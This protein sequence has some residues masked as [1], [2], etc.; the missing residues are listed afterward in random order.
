MSLPL[1]I[2]GSL[3]AIVIGGGNYSTAL[4]T[5]LIILICLFYAVYKKNRKDIVA[6]AIITLCMTIS[7]VISVKAPGNAVRQENFNSPNAIVAIIMSI[8]YAGLKILKIIP[9]PVSFLILMLSPILYNIAKK[10]NLSFKFPLAVHIFTFLLFASYDTPPWYAMG[11]PG[12]TRLL[13]GFH[14]LLILLLIFNLFYLLGWI[15]KNG[16][17]KNI[18]VKIIADKRNAVIWTL[19]LLLLSGVMYAVKPIKLHTTAICESAVNSLVKNE[20]QM[21][22]SEYLERMETVNKDDK[23]IIFKEYSVK[24]KLLFVGDATEDPKHWINSPMAE[25]YDKESIVVLPR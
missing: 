5:E 22:Y 4:I 13:N 18:I 7:F 11:D 9:T 6:M 14:Y 23:K 10:S 1:L 2:S 17:D 24:P 8:L 21:Y 3:L 20:A 16:S 15:V 19:C 12:A 25:W